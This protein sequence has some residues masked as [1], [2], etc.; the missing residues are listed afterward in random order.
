[1][2]D[3]AISPLRRRMIE[4]MAIRKLAPKT[5]HDYV[6]RVKDF[7]AFLGRS[8]D[9][10]KSEEVRGFRLHLTS[11]GAGTPSACPVQKRTAN[12]CNRLHDQHSNFG[13]H[14]HGGQC[15][16]ERLGQ[17]GARTFRASAPRF[18]ELRSGGKPAASSEVAR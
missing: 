12:L 10:A 4:D 16:P 3:Q 5:Q 17:V 1:M 11:S 14:D 6:Q 2:T 8:P 15:G 13:S 7:A 9:M 18:F